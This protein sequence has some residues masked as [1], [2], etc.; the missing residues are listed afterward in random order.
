METQQQQATKETG[1]Q[2]KKMLKKKKKK[3]EPKKYVEQNITCST[4]YYLLSSFTFVIQKYVVCIAL[5]C[6]IAIEVASI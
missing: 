2:E 3:E 5:H 1:K 6:K 4:L